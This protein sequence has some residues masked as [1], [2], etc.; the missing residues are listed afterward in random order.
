MTALRSML[1]AE[2]PMINAA[3]SIT[4]QAGDRLASHT[5]TGEVSAP[6][7][8]IAKPSTGTHVLPL[9]WETAPEMEVGMMVNS[10]VAVDMSGLSPN[11]RRN[12][13]TMMVPPPMPKSPDRMP[14]KMP[15]RTG[16]PNA[17]SRSISYSSARLRWISA[18]A[19]G[20]IPALS[21]AARR[22]SSRGAS[23]SA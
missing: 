20:S 21:W 16:S 2:Y 1:T 23:T 18:V 11:A 22:P 13:G 14:M 12:T 10:D 4:S 15:T 3:A 9:I 7:T 17:A 8:P 6:P 5:P 19:P